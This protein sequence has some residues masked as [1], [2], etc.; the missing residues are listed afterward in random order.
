VS[1]EPILASVRSDEDMLRNISNLKFVDH[2]ITDEQLFPELAK[3]KYSSV[4]SISN[5]RAF[6]ASSVNLYVDLKDLVIG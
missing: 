2:D 6:I 3:E 5:A 4:E 1:V